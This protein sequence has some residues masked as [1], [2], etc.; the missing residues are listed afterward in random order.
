MGEH[1][2]TGEGV[3]AGT[4]QRIMARRIGGMGA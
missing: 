4:V 3:L 2:C 1:I